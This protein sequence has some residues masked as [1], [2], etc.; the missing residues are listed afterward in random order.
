RHVVGSRDA[1]KAARPATSSLV[2]GRPSGTAE[3]RVFHAVPVS[4]PST[5]DHCSSMSFHMSVSTSPG[6]IALTVMWGARLADALC[7]RLMTAA[8]LARQWGVM[9]ARGPA[10]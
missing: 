8:L 5:A 4:H 3:V 9:G 10:A 1:R 2:C 6:Q 7:V